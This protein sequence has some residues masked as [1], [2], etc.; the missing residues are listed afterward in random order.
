MR[1][2]GLGKSKVLGEYAEKIKEFDAEGLLS[3]L[4]DDDIEFV[5]AIAKHLQKVLVDGDSQL[6]ELWEAFVVAAV[7]KKLDKTESNA[8]HKGLVAFLL[9]IVP[10]VYDGRKSTLNPKIVVIGIEAGLLGI[11]GRSNRIYTQQL[12]NDD[13]SKLL[14]ETNDE[15]DTTNTTVKKRKLDNNQSLSASSEERECAMA[16]QNLTAQFE[17]NH[18]YV[19]Y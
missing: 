13:L 19:S 4:S 14:D 3:G 10:K 2:N 9:A 5:K 16:M 8:V 7:N 11:V 18:R 12:K 6:I 1:F 17:Q 15:S